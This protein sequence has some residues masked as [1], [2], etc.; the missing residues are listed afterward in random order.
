[1]IEEHS[2]AVKHKVV[3]KVEKNEDD[4]HWQGNEHHF[5]TQVGVLSESAVAAFDLVVDDITSD[6]EV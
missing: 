5:R 3:E 6:H 4:W 1:M 2:P